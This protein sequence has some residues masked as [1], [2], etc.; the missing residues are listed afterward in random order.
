MG[1]LSNAFSTVMEFIL[2]WVPSGLAK[3]MI[4]VFTAAFL[5]I[6]VKI[7]LAVV[8]VLTKVLDLFIPL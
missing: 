4:G 2:A 3:P 7:I 8:D 6:L 1:G 5:I